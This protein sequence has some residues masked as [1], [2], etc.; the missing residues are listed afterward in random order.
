MSACKN[1]D[2]CTTPHGCRGKDKCQN[3]LSEL[4]AMPCSVTVVRLEYA[5]QI[6]SKNSIDIVRHSLRT[7]SEPSL[8]YHERIIG[9]LCEALSQNSTI[10]G[11]SAA[12]LDTTPKRSSHKAE[13]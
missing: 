5:W 6:Q 13:I 10:G 9:E 1:E 2:D 11:D 4:A 7:A 8:N 3:A 12:I